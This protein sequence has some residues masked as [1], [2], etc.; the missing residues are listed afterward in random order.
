MKLIYVAGPYRSDGT[1]GIMQ[2]IRKAEDVTVQLWNLGVAVICPHK[3]TAFLDGAIDGE[4][5]D[6]KGAVADVSLFFKGDL[7]MMVRCD[8][9]VLVPGWQKSKG[10]VQ[11][12]T[13]AVIRGIPVFDWG[14]EQKQFTEWL[15]NNN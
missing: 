13:L 4:T 3:N 14:L 8:A 2:N 11:E 10:T 9:V 6:G 12:K 5:M 1:Y 15:A 7:E